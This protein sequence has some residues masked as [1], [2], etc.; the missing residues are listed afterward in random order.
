VI[1]PA[2]PGGNSDIFFRQLS[3]RMGEVL[4]QQLIIDYRP[5]AGNRQRRSP[6]KVPRRLYHGNCRRQLRDQSF[7]DAQAPTTR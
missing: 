7:A 3:P 1:N 4:G 2:A 5:G 6:Q